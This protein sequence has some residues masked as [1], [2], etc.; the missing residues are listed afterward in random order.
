[1]VG[2]EHEG[3]T[4]ELAPLSPDVQFIESLWDVLDCTVN[5]RSG[6]KTNAP[7]DGNNITT[8]SSIK[9]CVNFWTR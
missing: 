9:R 7:L 1:M 5:T 6:S 3:F 2:R 4:D 8:F